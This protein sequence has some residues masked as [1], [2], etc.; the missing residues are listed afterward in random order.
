MVKLKIL[1]MEN[2]LVTVNGCKGKVNMLCPDGRKRNI[3]GE[4]TVQDSLRHQY[5][6]NRNCLQMVLEISNPKD[7]MSIVSYYAGD[8]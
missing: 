1:D 2:F 8:C 5:R 7:Y 4:E 6:Q 3:N